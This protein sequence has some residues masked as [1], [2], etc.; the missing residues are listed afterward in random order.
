[1][2]FTLHSANATAV[3]NFIYF[4]NYYL[5]YPS[6]LLWFT[7]LCKYYKWSVCYKAMEAAAFE[8]SGP[9]KKSSYNCCKKETISNEINKIIYNPGVEIRSSQ[10]GANGA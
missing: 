5:Q 9:K 3:L 6:D 7:L 1:M 10:L 4:S 8:V 2:K